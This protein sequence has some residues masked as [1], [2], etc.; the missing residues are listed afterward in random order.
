MFFVFTSFA[1][2]GYIVNSNKQAELSE[3]IS[4]ENFS[5]IPMD[6]NTLK[7]KRLEHQPKLRKLLWFKLRFLKQKNTET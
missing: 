5:I 3:T 7:E 4:M 1:W 6:S 2:Y